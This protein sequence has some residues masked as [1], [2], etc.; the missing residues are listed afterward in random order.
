MDIPFDLRDEALMV[1]CG[2]FVTLQDRLGRGVTAT[3]QGYRMLASGH[4]RRAVEGSSQRRAAGWLDQLVT[5]RPQPAG[6]R[7]NLR[8]GYQYDV[9]DVALSE[10]QGT[11]DYRAGGKCIRDGFGF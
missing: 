8:V 7:R 4:I 2:S 11:F 9:I 1:I 6:R 5:F 3:D 10:E